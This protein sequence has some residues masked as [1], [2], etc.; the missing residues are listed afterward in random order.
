MIS[1]GAR[2]W[3][4]LACGRM[5]GMQCIPVANKP[6]SLNGA[7][8]L[9]YVLNCKGSEGW[10]SF[11]RRRRKK[12]GA[13]LLI[14]TAKLKVKKTY[15]RL[16]APAL[17]FSFHVSVY[18]VKHFSIQNFSLFSRVFTSSSSFKVQKIVQKGLNN[19]KK[20]RKRLSE[21]ML[22]FKTKATKEYFSKW[23]KK[24]KKNITR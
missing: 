15:S 19:L 10:V 11:I 7:G 24:R 23:Q 17:T 5:H 9:F 1:D 22:L 12:N 20:K 3:H 16:S 14:L 2:C 21:K 8:L 4:C 6:R 13:D 18:S